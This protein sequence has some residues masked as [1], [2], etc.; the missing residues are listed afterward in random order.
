MSAGNWLLGGGL[1]SPNAFYA[2]KQGP[3]CCESSVSEYM[4]TQVKMF[5]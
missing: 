2:Q 3:N 5:R 1:H 4:S